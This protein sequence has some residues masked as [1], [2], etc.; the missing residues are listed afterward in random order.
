MTSD[1]P[2]TPP[3]TESSLTESAGQASSPL[4]WLTFLGLIVGA[5]ATRLLPHPENLTAVGAVA[6]FGGVYFRRAS[7]AVVVP[8][9]A[10]LLS[11][12]VLCITW[13]GSDFAHWQLMSPVHYVLFAVTAL[14][15]R[16]MRQQPSFGRILGTTIA[17]TALYYLVS[18]FSEWVRP[19]SGARLYPMTLGGLIQCYVAGLPFVR[20]M[21]IG[22]LLYTSLLFG[23]WSVVRETGAKREL[24][25]AKIRT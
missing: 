4:P 22:N 11:D 7:I 8:I 15:G 24:A 2:Y 14:L 18:N 17:A 20:N 3:L 25:L 19:E 6:L 23:G 16:T 1:N 9:L 10:L 12:V 13:M 5:A 21:L